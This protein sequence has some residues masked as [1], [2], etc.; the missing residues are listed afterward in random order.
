MTSILF[1]CLGNICRSPAA[2][3][4]L[5][6]MAQ[7]AAPPI[8]VKVESCGLGDWHQG[9]LADERMRKAANER[10]IV[11]SSRA[12]A[13]KPE[14]FEEFDYIFAADNS[15]LYELHKCA[16]SPEHKAKIHLM[17]QFSFTYSNQEIPDPYYANQGHFDLVL[18]M[19]EDCCQGIV[20]H[21]TSKKVSSN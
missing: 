16:K 5:V 13:F 1:V 2:E 10:G 7:A 4:I 20:H 12:Q 19:L 9:Q 8:P 11:L 6:Q 15:V 17:S 21:L 18:D 3:G 14:F